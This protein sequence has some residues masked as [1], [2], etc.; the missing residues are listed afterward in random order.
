MM[1]EAL[2]GQLGSPDTA[3]AAAAKWSAEVAGGANADRATAEGPA[4]EPARPK[5]VARGYLL[6]RS[7]RGPS[8]EKKPWKKRY[9]V[10]HGSTLLYYR[11]ENMAGA[12]KVLV[13]LEAAGCEIDLLADSPWNAK[14]SFPFAIRQGGVEIGLAVTEDAEARDYWWGPASQPRGLLHAR[15]PPLSSQPHP[16]PLFA[17]PHNHLIQQGLLSLR[18]RITMLSKARGLPA[19]ELADQSSRYAGSSTVLRLRMGVS[20]ALASSTAGRAILKLY[21]D[22]DS[23]ALIAGLLE[24]AR[25]ERS[26]KQVRAMEKAAFDIMARIGVIVH[27]AKMPPDLDLS[28]LCE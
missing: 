1:E 6:K 9:F 17:V 14:A 20:A 15:V 12:H 16:S 26:A 7:R 10:L 13:T 19:P 28:L 2:H 4:R 11:H 3:G 18:R 25:A 23:R 5:V 22:A 8:N 21:L 27:A 24:F